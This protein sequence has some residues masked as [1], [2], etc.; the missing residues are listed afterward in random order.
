MAVSKKIEVFICEDRTAELEL[1]KLFIKNDERLTIIGEALDGKTALEYLLKNSPD[2]VFMDIHM[3]YKTGIE[4][5][6]ELSKSGR[7]PHVIFTTAFEEF[8]VKA[9][10]VGAVDYV[11]KP[12]TQ[13]RITM[14]IDRAIQKLDAEQGN[15]TKVTGFS[16]RSSNRI[17]NIPYNEIIYF[18]S[19]GRSSVLHKQ[20]EDLEIPILMKDVISKLP[21]D[22]FMRIHKQFIVNLNHVS[23]LKY[24]SSGSYFAILK[25]DQ[26]VLTVSAGYAKK[27]K[28]LFSG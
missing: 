4:I 24:R 7:F 21:P 9:F 13:K 27:F 25:D 2:I 12:L 20:D 18:S 11:I 16:F 14:A 19:N 15:T 8:A 1:L 10:E 28:K 26:D 6:E 23:H 22:I 17:Y 5:A 3:P